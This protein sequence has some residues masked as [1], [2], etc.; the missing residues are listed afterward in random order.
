LRGEVI[1]FPEAMIDSVSVD[2]PA[3]LR[4]TL[5]L[6]WNTFGLDWCNMYN[7]T[8]VW[9]GTAQG[10]E[11]RTSSPSNIWTVVRTA[12]FGNRVAAN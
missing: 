9:M 6:V 1:A 7:G 12:K 10:L 3:L 4:T 5:N 2:M 8:I 11:H